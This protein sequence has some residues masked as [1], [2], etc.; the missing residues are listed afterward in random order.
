[1][2]QE[3]LQNLAQRTS[4]LPVGCVLNHSQCGASRGTSWDHTSQ[5][6]SEEE[7]KK[8][9]RSSRQDREPR[10]LVQT[11]C[12]D[13]NKLGSRGNP[14]DN[15]RNSADI[16]TKGRCSTIEKPDRSR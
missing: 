6:F 2:K 14:Q 4:F 13:H 5:Q 16:T 1:M 7:Q 11:R 15:D 8:V 12:D 9:E 3:K 10:R